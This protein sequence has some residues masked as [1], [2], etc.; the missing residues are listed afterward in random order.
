MSKTTYG[1]VEVG[2]RLVC[3][4]RREDPARLVTSVRTHPR[5][6][7]YVIIGFEDGDYIRPP[8]SIP[9]IRLEET[10]EGAHDE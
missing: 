9:F 6:R 2:D 10:S 5:D 8:K 3:R 1:E 4:S 7:D